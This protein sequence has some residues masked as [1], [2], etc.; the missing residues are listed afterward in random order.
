MAG[1]GCTEGYNRDWPNYNKRLVKRGFA[2]LNRPRTDG[3]EN[4]EGS[5]TKRG[6]GRPRV[7]DDVLIAFVCGLKAMLG[8]PYRMLEGMLGELLGPSG[9]GVPC[10][11]TL[12]KRC[13]EFEAQRKIC[14]DGKE[15]IVAID[16]TGIK[17]TMRGEWMRNKWKVRRGWLKLHILTDVETNEI[18][19]FIVTDERS[20]D[21]K[22]MLALVDDALSKGYNIIKVLADGAY[23]T[24]RNWNGMKH[25][26]IEFV[27]NIRKNASTASKGC[28]CRAAAVR[29]RNEI[30]DE[31]WKEKHGYRMRWKVE[32]AISDL[33]RMFGEYVFSKTFANMVKE[34][35]RNIDAF[36]QLK[37]VTT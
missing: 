19:S 22:H 16:S 37:R 7:Y 13:N 29:E 10:Y 18:L 28:T 26:K 24:R 32:S 34:I 33:K 30:G 15:R 9:A 12:W 20:G 27:T 1:M 14:D 8:K 35:G 25:R 21:A 17:V 6:K 36:N 23:D 5:G 11:S 3:N 2:A 31:A 4:K